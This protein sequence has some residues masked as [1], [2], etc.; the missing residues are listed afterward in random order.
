MKFFFHDLEIFILKEKCQN[1]S[2]CSITIKFHSYDHDNVTFIERIN[3]FHFSCHRY[4]SFEIMLQ[5]IEKALT[6]MLIAIAIKLVGEIFYLSGKVIYLFICLLIYF[7][8]ILQI[9]KLLRTY[10]MKVFIVA[11]I[12]IMLMKLVDIIYHEKYYIDHESTNITTIN[13]PYS[14]F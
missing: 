9:E 1:I 3:N 2:V 10:L 12:P 5:I 13:T 14:I 6:I 8:M 4:Y 11:N 7:D